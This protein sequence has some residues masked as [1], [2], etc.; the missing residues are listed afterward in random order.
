MGASTAA[1]SAAA[2]AAGAAGLALF[3]I[4]QSLCCFGYVFM[5]ILMALAIIFWIVAI[6]DVVQRPDAYFPEAIAGRRNP[7]E[8][9]I[10]VLVVVFLGWIGALVYYFLV[11]KK[12][13]RNPR[14]PR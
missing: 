11:M 5:M 2:D 13:P 3:G 4:F 9:L 1:S 7:N 10:W 14:S 12:Y 6:V 8:R